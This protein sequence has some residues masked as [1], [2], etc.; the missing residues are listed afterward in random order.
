MS[1]ASSPRSR[2]TVAEWRSLLSRFEQSGLDVEAF[3]KRESISRSSFHRWRRRVAGGS[4]VFAEV[5]LPTASPSSWS[6]E[7]ALPGDIVL[8]IRG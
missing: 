6:V 8:R 3:C 1:R 5:P 7:L 2:R 4:S